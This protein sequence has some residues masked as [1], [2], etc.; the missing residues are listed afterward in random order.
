MI[1]EKLKLSPDGYH[2]AIAMNT[3]DKHI[4]DVWHTI[5][6]NRVSRLE[7]SESEGVQFFNWLSDESLLIIDR[8]GSCSVWDINK[9]KAVDK[10]DCIPEAL[11]RPIGNIVASG[12]NNVVQIWKFENRKWD[13]IAELQSHTDDVDTI[14]WSPNGMKLASSSVFG[15]VTIWD[16]SFLP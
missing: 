3:N 16:T 1:W 7:I 13:P 10:F 15:V 9:N 6:T 5:S 8:N 14:A 12:Y 2:L 4:I 11:F